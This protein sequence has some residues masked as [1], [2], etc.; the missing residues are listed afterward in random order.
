MKLKVRLLVFRPLILL[1]SP[2]YCEFPSKTGCSR[3]CSQLLVNIAENVVLTHL[4]SN[5]SQQN[6]SLIYVVEWKSR[7]FHDEVLIRLQ[8]RLEAEAV[9]LLL[10]RFSAVEPG[11]LWMH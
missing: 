7:P 9:R 6:V 5:S 10:S 11:W 3:L 4:R 8:A 2:Y 1:F